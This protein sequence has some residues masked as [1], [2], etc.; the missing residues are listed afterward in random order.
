MR[1]DEDAR[2]RDRGEEREPK[3]VGKKEPEE[4]PG[5]AMERAKQTKGTKRQAK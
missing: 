3:E 4:Q 5:S 2:G 1:E